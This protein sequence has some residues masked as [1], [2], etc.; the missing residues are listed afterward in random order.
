[1]VKFSYELLP[2]PVSKCDYLNKLYSYLRTGNIDL[3][4]YHIAMFGFTNVQGFH[5]YT[6]FYEEAQ[7]RYNGDFDTMCI[8]EVVIDLL[9]ACL[10]TDFAHINNRTKEKFKTVTFL[11]IDDILKNEFD[12]MRYIKSLIVNTFTLNKKVGRLGL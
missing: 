10:K 12:N 8:F 6:R 1:M 5:W 3:A 7:R 11:I 4:F 2:V 9:M